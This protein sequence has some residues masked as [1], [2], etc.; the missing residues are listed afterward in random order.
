MPPVT[1]EMHIFPTSTRVDTAWYTPEEKVIEILF[2]DGVRWL[3]MNVEPATWLRFKRS[4]SPGRYLHDILERH[5]NR[6]R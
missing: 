1:R 6:R 3:F 4:G 5:P 2:P